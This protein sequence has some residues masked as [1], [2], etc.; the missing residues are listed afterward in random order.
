[1]LNAHRFDVVISDWCLNENASGV[2]VCR[3]AKEVQPW[4]TTVIL[5]AFDIPQDSYWVDRYLKKEVGMA[6][7]CELLRVL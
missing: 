2:D 5:T 1:M 7:L 6:R 3:K 4:A